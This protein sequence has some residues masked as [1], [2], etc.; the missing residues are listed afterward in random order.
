MNIRARLGFEKAGFGFF[1]LKTRV[2]GSGFGFSK[3]YQIDD[4]WLKNGAFWSKNMQISLEI[5]K[6]VLFGPENGDYYDFLWWFLSK[7]SKNAY[8]WHVCL[9]ITIFKENISTFCFLLISF[10]QICI[11]NLLF[12]LQLKK[13]IEMSQKGDIFTRFR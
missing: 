1:I 6:L 2:P 3:M 9:F 4:F 5:A 12:D 11:C 13:Y 8:I 7:H 10:G